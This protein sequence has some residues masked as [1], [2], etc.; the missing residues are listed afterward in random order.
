MT[1]Q[2]VATAQWRALDREGEDKCTLAHA[3]HGWVL[4]GH[5]R[6]RDEAGFAALD[7]VIR[8]DPAWQTINA[9]IAGLHGE[10]DVK[11]RLDCD[12]GHW[13][14]NDVPQPQVGVAHVLDL[15]FTPATNLLPLR[16]LSE[17]AAPRL[18]MRVAW[19][20]YPDQ[21]LEPLDQTYT[22]GGT[23]DHVLYRGEQTG[24]SVHLQVDTTGF[25]TLYPGLWEGEVTAAAPD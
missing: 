1:G 12:K 11:L 9:D 7:Y 10:R 23:L 21:A 6:F 15:S 16:R 24:S 20:R 5:A 8:C 2:Q 3:D 13:T 14:L 25:V 4:L 18:S 22:A 19:L 17:Q